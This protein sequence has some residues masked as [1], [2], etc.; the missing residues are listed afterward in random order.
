MS[1]NRISI[2]AAADSLAAFLQ[3]HVPSGTAIDLSKE[4]A[5]QLTNSASNLVAMAT[6]QGV[7][8]VVERQAYE[9]V[10][11]LSVQIESWLHDSDLEDYLLEQW[12][13][14]ILE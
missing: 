1:T 6:S 8:I 10:G 4:L 13:K 5:D 12:A 3:S 9:A 7:D 2:V 11:W 14:T